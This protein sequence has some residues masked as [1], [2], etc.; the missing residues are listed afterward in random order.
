MRYPA[1]NFY[2]GHSLSFDLNRTGKDEFRT[3]QNLL[4]ESGIK[5]T[6]NATCLSLEL[7]RIIHQYITKY[8][9]GMTANYLKY[10]NKNQITGSPIPADISLAYHSFEHL[11]S[12]LDPYV[13][14]DVIGGNVLIFSRKICGFLRRKKPQD[15]LDKE[16]KKVIEKIVK[17]ETTK[18][19]KKLSELQSEI[20]PSQTKNRKKVRKI[21]SHKRKV[22]K[23]G[24]D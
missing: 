16:A 3:M 9:K 1:D 13:T 8:G 10:L 17:K 15:P 19:F 14:I 2:H 11:M 7:I 20:K 22:T 21:S 6:P 12:Y 5:P 23:K 24:T 18:I 4:K